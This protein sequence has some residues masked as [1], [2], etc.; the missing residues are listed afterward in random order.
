MLNID[1]SNLTPGVYTYSVISGAN[2]I[3]KTMMVK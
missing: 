1:G 2:K 3:S